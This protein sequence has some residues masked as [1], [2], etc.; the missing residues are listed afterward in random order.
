MQGTPQA[1]QAASNAANAVQ[2][3]TPS[4]AISQLRSKIENAQAD[5]TIQ[6]KAAEA[7]PAVSKA[8]WGTFIALVLTLIAS[9]LGAAVGRRRHP[10]VP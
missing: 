10:A 5:G 1:N 7:K 3:G 9:V 6:E 8:A 2:N 4:D